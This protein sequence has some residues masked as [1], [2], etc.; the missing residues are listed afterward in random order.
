MNKIGFPIFLSTL[1]IT[2]FTYGRSKRE[3]LAYYHY[4]PK[5]NYLHPN[6]R[7]YDNNF[8]G[9]HDDWKKG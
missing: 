1:G 3:A 7:N 6:Y 9:W 2:S 5:Y 4:H 8:D